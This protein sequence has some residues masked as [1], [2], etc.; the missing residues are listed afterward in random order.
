VSRVRAAPQ[1]ANHRDAFIQPGAAL[2][3]R[4][5]AGFEL[6]VE[7]A[8]HADSEDELALREAIEGGSLL[9]DARPEDAPPAHRRS[10]GE[11][12]QRGEHGDAEAEMAVNP[13]GIVP[14]TLD[15]LDQEPVDSIDMARR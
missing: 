15:Q 13:Q 2:G 7:F 3:D 4:D 5:A 11:L 8:A 9:G 14:A 10:L 12:Q 1:P 6:L